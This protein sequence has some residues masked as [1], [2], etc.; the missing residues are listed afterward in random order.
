[1]IN[2][3]D[4]IRI[5]TKDKKPFTFIS[6]TSY[7]TGNC[8][9]HIVEGIVTSITNSFQTRKIAIETKDDGTIY[10]FENRVLENYNLTILESLGNVKLSDKEKLKIALNTLKLI[11]NDDIIGI[12]GS[13]FSISETLNEIN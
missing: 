9:G 7:S 4:R 2:L 1:M 13:N 12:D 8:G 10:F 11:S 5:E 6:Y 3:N